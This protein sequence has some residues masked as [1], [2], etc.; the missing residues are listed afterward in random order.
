MG[1][2]QGEWISTNRKAHN[3]TQEQLALAMD[4]SVRT[5]KKWEK[6][7]KPSRAQRV[8]LTTFFK[9]EFPR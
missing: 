6:G 2:R 3:M 7:E 8:L 4:V 5:I 1:V 9:K